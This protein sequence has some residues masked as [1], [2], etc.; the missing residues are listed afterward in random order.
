[1]RKLLW[2]A[3]GFALA[4]G[5]YSY[6]LPL[7]FYL[8]AAGLS[9]FLLA[10]CLFCMLRFPKLR[11]GAMVSFAATVGFIWCFGFDTI[12]LAPL[13]NY[14]DQ[15]VL[16]TITATDY[17]HTTDYGAVTEGRVELDGK[18]YTLLLYHD[19]ETLLSPG[20][21]V[22]G[23]VNL[24]CTLAGGMQESQINRADRIFL[25]ARAKGELEIQPCQQLPLRYYPSVMRYGILTAIRSRF[26]SDVAEFACA[27]LLGETDGID[28]ETDTALKISGIRHVIAV[29]GL[30]VTILFSL[31]F[32]L[33]GNRKWITAILGIPVLF[34]FAAVA[35]FSPSITRACMMHTL[36]IVA[37][38]L[39]KEY[40]PL[41][42][43][44]FAVVCMISINPFVIAN[45]SLQLSVACMLG[46]IL[47][48]DKIKNFL[49]DKKRLG[50]FKG[51]AKKLAGLF[52]TSISVSL[53]SMILTTPLCVLYFG[54]VSLIGPLTN[55]LTLWIISFIFY[56][57]MLVCVIG[58]FL[59]IVGTMIAWLV[60]WPIRYVL[61]IAKVMASVPLSAVY[62]QSV[63][64]VCWLIFVYVL[65]LVFLLSKKKRPILLGCLA[66]IALCFSLVASWTEPYLDDCRVTV[67]DVGQGQCVLLQ[68]EG[69]SYLVDC[70]S[71]SD[72]YAAD[73][74]A[75]LLLSQ[76]ITKL[77]GIF[78]TH[79]DDDHVGGISNLLT[80]ITVSQIYS[81]QVDEENE[82][83]DFGNTEVIAVDKKQLF[84]FGDAKITLIPSENASSGNESSL[85]ILFQT[86]N[87]DTL[88]TGDRTAAG[89]RELVEQNEIP[90]IEVLIVGH[91]GSKTSTSRELLIKTKPEIA[92][93]SV[94]ADNS[95]GHPAEEVLSRLRD[96]GCIIYR[97]DLLGTILYRG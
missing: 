34:L 2:F 88:I 4:A 68:S 64:I 87:C 91:H 36:M 74:A 60:A 31:V 92:I 21:Q 13:R 35:G 24:R 93:I 29:S 11:I 33:T 58:A 75:N 47:F 59:P 63:Y 8:L 94:G 67:L 3:V 30:H 76:G 6:V 54:M 32:V 19:Q 77:D 16:L 28:Y 41:T 9:A 96:F 51:R 18:A 55:L 73:Q 72:N 42:A 56:G 45:V 46:I 61:W 22:A 78:I 89:E 5:L 17:S 65:L 70:G 10:I 44:S 48:S 14:D 7:N 15:T 39:N 52:S 38:L 79:F 37:M 81:P 27:L 62:T 80:R 85:C 1:M 26:P 53:S 71:D 95:Y 84:T 50:Q 86:K 82:S 66:T 23:E 25:T 90:D 49:M 12:Y 57:I 20:D 40:D 43:L 69:R 83:Y 97:T